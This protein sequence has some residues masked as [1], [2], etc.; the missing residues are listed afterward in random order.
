MIPTPGSCPQARTVLVVSANAD[1]RAVK[2]EHAKTQGHVVVSAA[3]SAL[4][5]TTFDMTQPDIVVTDL[6]C[7]NRTGSIW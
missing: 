3:T 6:F 1:T 2:L 7:L 4:G 5:L